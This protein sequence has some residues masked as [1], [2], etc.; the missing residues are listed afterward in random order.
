VAAVAGDVDS[1]V[2]MDRARISK[3]AYIDRGIAVLDLDMLLCQCWRHDEYEV[4]LSFIMQAVEKSYTPSEMYSRLVYPLNSYA[5]EFVSH[6][7]GTYAPD[8]GVVERAYRYLE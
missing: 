1:I 7:L 4:L 5:P 8:R 6:L 3:D 2:T